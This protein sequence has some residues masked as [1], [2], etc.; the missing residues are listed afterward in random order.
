MARR[1]YVQVRQPVHGTGWRSIPKRS[2]TWAGGIFG[3]PS[4]PQNRTGNFRSNW[5]ISPYYQGGDTGVFAPRTFQRIPG[6]AMWERQP[7][8]SPGLGALAGF[9]SERPG[10]AIVAAIG[11]VFGLM[12]LFGKR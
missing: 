8:L 7:L 10:L 5:A 9:F 12:S 2:I 1:Y 6:T 3:Q 11:L 4:L